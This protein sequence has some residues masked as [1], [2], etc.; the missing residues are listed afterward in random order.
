MKCSDLTNIINDPHFLINIPGSDLIFIPGDLI[1]HAAN[2]HSA[3]LKSH[4]LLQQAK[5]NSINMP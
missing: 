1:Y 5:S 3:Q 2:K 4:Y